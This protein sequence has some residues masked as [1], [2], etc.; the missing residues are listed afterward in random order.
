M[1]A[2]DDHSCEETGMENF[3]HITEP[4]TRKKLNRRDCV[5][6]RRLCQVMNRFSIFWI[7]TETAGREKEDEYEDGKT[8]T[9]SIIICEI[10]KRGINWISLI[11]V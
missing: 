6:L 5:K 3:L 10:I 1:A 11:S 8:M 2:C 7:A 4:I 9:I